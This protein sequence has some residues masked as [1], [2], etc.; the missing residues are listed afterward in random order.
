M[1]NIADVLF[2]STIIVGAYL[3]EGA[4][5][6]ACRAALALAGQHR[7]RAHIC[8]NALGQIAED[9]ARNEGR[10]PARVWLDETRRSLHVVPTSNEILDAALNHCL[11]V[12]GLYLDDAITMHTARLTEM[13]L[14]VTLN[15]SDF[16]AATTPIVL[17]QQ[18][19]DRFDRQADVA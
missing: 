7:I 5:G 12:D 4:P 10:G 13:A 9:I 3:A 14:I 8:G 11:S 6:A 17:P 1:E 18:L 16:S 15:G 2:D 19:L